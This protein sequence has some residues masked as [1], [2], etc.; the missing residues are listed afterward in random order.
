MSQLIELK[1]TPEEAKNESIIREKLLSVNP[2][3]KDDF[4]FRWKKRSFDA[5]SRNIKVNALFEIFSTKEEV[6]ELKSFPFRDV[7]NAEKIHIVGA[8]PAGLFAA[9][10][11]IQNGFCPI[12]FERG[13]DVQARRRDLAR[14]N[15]EHLV[16]SESNYCFG[17][18]GAGTYSDGKLYTRSKK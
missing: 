1:L 6:S 11:A 14:L 3:L 9:L 13:K 8:G 17:E 4:I 16:N 18:G 12:V 15:K 5:R 10:R 7:R 2:K